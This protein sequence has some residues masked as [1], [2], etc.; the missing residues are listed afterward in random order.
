MWCEDA[1]SFNERI[2]GFFFGS[3]G[4]KSDK[5][6]RKKKKIHITRRKYHILNMIEIYI[7][8]C[9]CVLKY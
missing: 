1:L 7:F 9:G 2:K 4:E 3:L 5:N 8:R 6:T